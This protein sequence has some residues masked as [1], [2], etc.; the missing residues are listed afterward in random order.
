MYSII[1]DMINGYTS[2]SYSYTH[3]RVV[4]FMLLRTFLFLYQVCIH[5]S[6]IFSP[7]PEFLK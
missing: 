4:G 3:S 6:F 5:S 2:L 7:F 1:E